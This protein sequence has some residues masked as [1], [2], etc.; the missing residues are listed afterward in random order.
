MVISKNGLLGGR[1]G[2]RPQSP[3]SR[4]ST[5]QWGPPNRPIDTIPPREHRHRSGL[6]PNPTIRN[7][8]RFRRAAQ[9]RQKPVTKALASVTE[10]VTELHPTVKHDLRVLQFFFLIFQFGP[11]SLLGK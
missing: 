11:R 2:N 8:D 5:L 1:D 9:Q 3:G 4:I 6:Q 10:N 7:P